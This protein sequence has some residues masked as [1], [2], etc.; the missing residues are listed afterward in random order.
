MPI[1]AV[2]NAIKFTND[3]SVV[4]SFNHNSTHT[5]MHCYKYRLTILAELLCFGDREFYKDWWNAKTVEEVDLILFD[6]LKVLNIYC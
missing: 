4:Y 3:N 2:K 6:M 5:Y 1:L